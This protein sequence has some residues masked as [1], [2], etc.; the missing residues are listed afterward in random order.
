[1]VAPLALPNSTYS[2][3]ASRAAESR[4]GPVQMPGLSHFFSCSAMAGP[5]FS[6]ITTKTNSTMMAPA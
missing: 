5:R 4:A 6:I 1:M 2:S 3:S